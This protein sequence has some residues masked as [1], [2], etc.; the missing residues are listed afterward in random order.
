MFQFC[1]L[2]WL[3]FGGNQGLAVICLGAVQILYY[4]LCYCVIV[5]LCYLM[6]SCISDDEMFVLLLYTLRELSCTHMICTATAEH[7][8]GCEW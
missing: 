7:L 8:R 5:T 1:A 4:I 2:F 3:L 6:L